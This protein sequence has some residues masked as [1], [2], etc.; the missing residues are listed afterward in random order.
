MKRFQVFLAVCILLFVLVILVSPST[1]HVRVQLQQEHSVHNPWSILPVV[2][3]AMWEPPRQDEYSEVMLVAPGLQQRYEDC[4]RRPNDTKLNCNQLLASKPTTVLQ[5]L[6]DV[7][8]RSR[9]VFEHAEARS[10]R[11]LFPATVVLAILVPTTSRK[12]QISHLTDL[13]AFGFLLPSILATAEP[14]FEYRIYLGYDEDDAYYDRPGRQEQIHAWFLQEIQT[15]AF[16]TKGVVIRLFLLCF[17]NPQKKP[18]PVMNFLSRQAYLDDAE[19]LYRINDDCQFL[20]P[21]ASILVGKLQSLG[22]PYGVLGPV[23]QEGFHSLALTQ[24][25]VHRT[26][27]DI[28]ETHYPVEFTDWFLDYWISR[29]YGPLRTFAVYEAPMNHWMSVTRYQI[30][31][32]TEIL[33]D[34]LVLHGRRTIISFLQKVNRTQVAEFETAPLKFNLHLKRIKKNS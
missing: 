28:F 32:T 17:R 3:Y 31:R 2:E 34:E 16:F 21:F 10:I 20:T 33:L 13:G 11:P 27:L 5:H 12:L 19:Y 22:F 8:K 1:R 18:G 4:K 15:P 7:W 14:G 24:D 23:N 29:V 30:N 26:H 9:K 6:Y 25:F